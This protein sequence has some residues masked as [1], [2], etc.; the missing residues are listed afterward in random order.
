MKMAAKSWEK[1]KIK[2]GIVTGSKTIKKAAAKGKAAT[3]K[4]PAK[5]TPAKKG[6][7]QVDEEDEEE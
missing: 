2:H 3:K 4:T 7:K 5:K 1:H 6:K